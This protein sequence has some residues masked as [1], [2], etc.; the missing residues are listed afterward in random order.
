MFPFWCC[1]DCCDVLP[2]FV[3][4]DG[5]YTANSYSSL[6]VYDAISQNYSIPMAPYSVGRTFF[7]WFND[8]TGEPVLLTYCNIDLNSFIGQ[9]SDLLDC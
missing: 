6:T 2:P 1:C 3:G 7:L 8:N 4:S 5:V 9:L